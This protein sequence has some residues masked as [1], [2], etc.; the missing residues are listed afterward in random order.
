M[1]ATST[2]EFCASCHSM[3]PQVYTFEASSHSNIDCV[4]CHIEP[5]VV[6][7]VEAKIFGLYELYVTVTNSE[8][9]IIHSPY[10]ISNEACERCHNMN[11][12]EATLL[13]T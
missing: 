3:A 4:A 1:K 13:V 7:Y 10:P 6:N 12:R 8:R 11:N 2:N 9:P 5:G